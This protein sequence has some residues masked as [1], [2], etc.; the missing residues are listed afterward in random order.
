MKSGSNDLFDAAPAQEPLAARMRP[1]IVDEFVGQDHILGPGRLLRRAIQADMLSSIILSGP[2]G[3][4]KT[5][6]ARVIANTTESVFV[7]LNAVLS[8]VKDVR[9]AIES[10]RETRRLHDRRT[11]LFVDEVHRWN[12]AQQDA[13]LPWVESGTVILIGATTENPFFEV[14]SALVSRSR[15]F[16][17]RALGTE[18]LARV[19]HTALTDPERGYG[20]YRVTIDDDALTHLISVADGDA[21][22]LLNAIQLA[23]E[24]TPDHFPPERDAEIHVDLEIAEESI[25][26]KAILYDKEGD[27][28]YDTISAFIKSLRGSDPDAALYWMARMIAGGEDPHYVLRRMLIMASE[29]VGLADPNALVVVQAAAQAFDR[30]GMPEGQ[31]HLSQAALYLATCP[32]SNSTLAFFDALSVVQEERRAEVPKHLRDANRDKEGFGHGEGYLYPHA[33]RDHWVAQAY[34]PGS[35]QGRIFY[36]PSNQGFE[37]AVGAE[38]RRRREIQ[39]AAM[40]EED[41]VDMLTFTPPEKGRE[42]WL[43]RISTSRNRTLTDVVSRLFDQLRISRHHL[44]LAV[45]RDPGILMWEAARRTPEG[46][47][48]GIFGDSQAREIAEHYAHE[49]PELERPVL[50]AGTVETLASGKIGTAQPAPEAEAETAGVPERV[51]HILLREAI[52][53]TPDRRAL[54]AALT[55]RLAADGTIALA[56]TVPSLGSRLSRLV[57]PTGSAEEEIWTAMREAEEELFT[58]GD[59]PLVNWNPESLCTDVE[60]VGFS[61]TYREVVTYREQRPVGTADLERWLSSGADGPYA[62]AIRRRLSPEHME[63]LRKRYTSEV[64]GKRVPWNRSVLFLVATASSPQPD[65]G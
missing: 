16:Q 61:I 24:T 18:E 33:Y 31:F 10:A 12:K 30:V 38:V 39:L 35:L 65:S 40:T 2:P 54:F 49:L 34:L 26:R 3:T 63:L 25:Q 21:R 5:T 9:E 11:I 47:V 29:D 41:P 48:Y 43:S 8:G 1:R 22:S 53:R 6:L 36:Q 32:K 7:S 27:Y 60:A 52:T 56:Q 45:G 28:H 64:A 4:G 62:A 19:A 20:K 17:L 46:R 58:N 14:N 37:N 15:I 59:D 13:L 42:R 51:E 44:V 55:R 23:V 57:T 50:I